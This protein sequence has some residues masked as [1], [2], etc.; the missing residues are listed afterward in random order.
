M[1]PLNVNGNALSA[2]WFGRG[3]V[4]SADVLPAQLEQLVPTF[5][6][7]PLPFPL[8]CTAHLLS[9]RLLRIPLYRHSL[10]VL[11]RRTITMK[12]TVGTFAVEA[13]KL[14]ADSSDAFGPLKSALGAVV[15]IVELVEVRVLFKSCFRCLIASTLR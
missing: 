8:C 2:W 12:E 1:I 13:L 7:G 14:A 3:V 4:R 10:A 6:P 5:K 11:R 15:H 9:F